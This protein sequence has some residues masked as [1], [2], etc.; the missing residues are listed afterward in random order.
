MERKTNK[1]GET[2]I[3]NGDVRAVIRQD[4]SGWFD[5]RVDQDNLGTMICWHRRYS[6]GDSHKHEDYEAFKKDLWLDHAIPFEQQKVVDDFFAGEGKHR[7]DE[8]IERVMADYE[9]LPDARR[10][11]FEMVLDLVDLRELGFPDEI[12]ALPL[13]LY[14][15]G[16]I[17]MSTGAFGCSWDSGQVGWIYC[18]KERAL[19]WLDSADETR[20]LTAL[21]GE[22]SEYD[23]YLTGDVWEVLV[24]KGACGCDQCD[25]VVDSCGGFLGEESAIEHAEQIIQSV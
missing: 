13:Y 18:T 11:M 23:Q 20:V 5:P 19:S 25:A 24:Y 8:I 1:K 3:C 2:V 16:G 4:S 15:H 14:D 7:E 10:A 22:V 21:K 6:L 17:T 9:V 12:I